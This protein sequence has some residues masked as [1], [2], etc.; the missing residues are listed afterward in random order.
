MYPGGSRGSTV[1]YENNS[2]INVQYFNSSSEGDSGV[3]ATGHTNYTNNIFDRVQFAQLEG[4]RDQYNMIL[5]CNTIVTDSYDSD[6]DS[7]GL[8]DGYELDIGLNA[9]DPVTDSDSLSDGWEVKYNASFGVDPLSTASDSELNSDV[10]MDTLS[11]SEEEE[12]T[13]SQEAT[14]LQMVTMERLGSL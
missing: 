4:G 2:F 14:L 3:S 1:S 13:T 8:N 6:S 11:L 9:S 5:I 10:D 12:L 7:D